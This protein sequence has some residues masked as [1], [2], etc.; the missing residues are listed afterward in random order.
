MRRSSANSL[1]IDYHDD[2]GDVGWNQNIPKI[3]TTMSKYIHL[4]SA[5]NNSIPSAGDGN[6]NPYGNQY[7]RSTPP[8]S[9]GPRS[10][11]ST[12]RRGASGVDEQGK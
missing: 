8:L 5:S 12:F 9:Q 3:G 4:I 1:Q 11:S 2:A 10:Q 7:N 6:T